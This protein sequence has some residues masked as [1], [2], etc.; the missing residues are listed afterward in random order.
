MES[1]YENDSYAC[2]QCEYVTTVEEMLKTHI[3]SQHLSLKSENDTVYSCDQCDYMTFMEEMLTSHIESQ[4]K[5]EHQVTN[6]KTFSCGI[7]KMSFPSGKNLEKHKKT[8]LKE[9]TEPNGN[10]LHFNRVKKENESDDIDLNIIKQSKL[11]DESRFNKDIDNSIQNNDECNNQKIDSNNVYNH[12]KQEHFDIKLEEYFDKVEPIS[13]PCY[14]HDYSCEKCGKQYKHRKS[15][16]SHI[17]S[18]HGGVTFSCDKCDLKYKHRKSLISHIA[19]AH[20]AVLFP[21]NKCGKTFKHKKSLK[22][23]N[24]SS[25]E[26]VLYSCDECEFKSASQRYLN[27][28]IKKVHEGIRYPCHKCEYIATERGSLKKHHRAIHEGI[29]Y[30]G[31]KIACSYCDFKS[32]RPALKKHIFDVHGE[33]YLFKNDKEQFKCEKCEYTTDRKSSLKEHIQ[34]QH[35]GIRYPCDKCDYIGKL[36]RSLQQHIKVNHQGELTNHYCEYC[37]HILKTSSG[38]KLHINSV[39][40]NIR[41]ACLETGCDYKGK[42]KWNLKLHVDS[43]HKKVKYPCGM[44]DYQATQTSNLAKHVEVKHKKS[45]LSELV[46]M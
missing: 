8:H 13:P 43:V 27:D 40:K 6:G 4:H 15:L 21:C 39:H 29:L 7:C 24:A 2:D 28:H 23:H 38:L 44:C 16:N 18:S 17:A 42:A 37:G 19:S 11:E 35:E 36:S 14:E 5:R 30:G 32:I 22:I 41:F 26:S 12:L 33:E 31:V 25:H 45:G 9:V 1:V 3:K 20:E 10:N 34:K 46:Y